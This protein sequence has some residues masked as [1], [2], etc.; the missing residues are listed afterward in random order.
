MR[1]HLLCVDFDALNAHRYAPCISK[2]AA[3]CSFSKLHCTLYTAVANVLSAIVYCALIAETRKYTICLTQSKKIVINDWYGNYS[4][5][6]YTLCLMR[7]H[8]Y[9]HISSS[10]AVLRMLPC[11]WS[12]LA[13]VWRGNGLGKS[14]LMPVIT[15][16]K[17]SP[18]YTAA[19]LHARCKS[20][21]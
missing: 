12:W 20:C 15:K 17:V 19:E 13:I 14:R 4:N 8:A 2:L 16:R 9:A 6:N 18:E 11:E 3:I 1:M 5:C 21:R 10:V 7:M